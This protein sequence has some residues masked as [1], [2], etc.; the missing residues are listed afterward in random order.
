MFKLPHGSPVDRK[1]PFISRI[2]SRS[3]HH[4]VGLDSEPGTRQKRLEWCGDA[5]FE[6]FVAELRSRLG[7]TAAQKIAGIT[8]SAA[9]SS[10]QADCDCDDDVGELQEGDVVQVRLQPLE[11]GSWWRCGSLLP[12]GW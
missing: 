6:K 5:D 3:Y 10:L 2:V 8:Y 7:L 12:S 11:L 1:A 4:E 9:G